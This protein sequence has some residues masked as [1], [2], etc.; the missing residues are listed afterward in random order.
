VI[1]VTVADRKHIYEVSLQAFEE[2]FGVR[3][4]SHL[5][6]SPQ[7]LE[8]ARHHLMQLERAGLIDERRR[9]LACLY[10]REI[11]K[12]EV[13]KTCIRWINPQLRFGLFAAASFS[14]GQL[15]GV[16]TGQLV[17]RDPL[18]LRVTDYTYRYPLSEGWR[19]LMIDAEQAGNELRFVN[20]SDTPNLHA[21]GVPL[22]GLL[23][24]LFLTRRSLTQG[25]QL[26][27]DYGERFWRSQEG[28]PLKL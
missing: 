26:T 24:L 14:S 1:C 22:D 27:I 9:F 28:D 17:R 8:L 16:Y 18:H 21:M 7:T 19:P 20:H 4:L 13:A 2:I 10:S 6:S 5:E 23:Y 25:E 12:G 11:R 3:Y 15:I